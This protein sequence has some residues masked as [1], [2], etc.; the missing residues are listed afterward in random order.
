MSDSSALQSIVE[1]RKVFAATG[2]SG[3]GRA[4]WSAAQQA[5]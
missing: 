2:P 3:T 1:M 4:A 5:E